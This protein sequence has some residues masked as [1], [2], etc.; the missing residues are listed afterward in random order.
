[1]EGWRPGLA[2]TALIAAACSGGGVAYQEAG[3]FACTPAPD[4]AATFATGAEWPVGEHRDLTVGSASSSESAVEPTD[5]LAVRVT[6][7]SSSADHASLSWESAP[8]VLPDLVHLPGVGG[9]LA[10]LGDAV[11]AERVVYD[12]AGGAFD[13]VSNVDEIRAT[14]RDTFD[15][16]EQNAALDFHSSIRVRLT[17][18]GLSDDALAG[19]FA[20]GPELYHRLDGLELRLG[21]P[22]EAAGVLPNA[23]GG[24]PF[25]A[26][27]VTELTDV[28]DG[29]GCASVRR[30]VSTDP[31]R[32]REV[33]ATSL[34]AQGVAGDS[35]EFEDALAAFSVGRVLVGQFDH[36]TGRLWKLSGVQ[37]VRFGEQRRFDTTVITDVTAV[38]IG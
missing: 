21:E 7:L 5:L 20:E 17:L 12:V 28:V 15:V 37:L 31:D 35:R 26:I 23:F 9:E 38:S 11:P 18:D 36:A 6:A 32:V 24:P 3:S 19:L 14:V 27:E 25:P 4:G 16:L 10:A 30:T 33:L 13:R 22:I 2:A 8:T 29:D 1:M 34:A